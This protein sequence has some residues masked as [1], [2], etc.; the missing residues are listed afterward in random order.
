M[1]VKV[2]T[3]GSMVKLAPNFYAYEFDCQCNRCS[4]TKIDLDLVKILQKARDHFK[5]P[6]TICGPYRCPAHNA[7]IPNASPNSKHCLGMAA[8]VKVKNHTPL[9]VAQFFESIGVLGIG[10]YEKEDCG[11]DFVHV[12]TRTTKSFWYGHRQAYRSTFG[13]AASTAT[14]APKE[15]CTVKLPVLAKGHKCDSVKHLQRLLVGHSYSVGNKGADGH[16][17]SATENG[18]KRFQKAHKLPETG[19]TDAATW[20]ALMD[21][22]S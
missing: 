15:T 2:Y 9:E 12:D 11:D 10:L 20:A 13:G 1:A 16:F 17:G 5:E 4:Q 6:V 22:D 19:K 21:A 7:E 18:L 14:Q 3:K 8:D